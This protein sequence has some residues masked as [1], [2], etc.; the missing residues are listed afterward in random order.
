LVDPVKIE[1][2]RKFEGKFLSSVD[3]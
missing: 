2:S 1:Y 3:L